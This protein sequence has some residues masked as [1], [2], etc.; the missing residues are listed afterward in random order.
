MWQQP[1]ERCR[2]QQAAK[3]LEPEQDECHGDDE[4]RHRVGAPPLDG[5]PYALR[6]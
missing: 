1:E 5:D 4:Q 3:Q 2:H 6:S